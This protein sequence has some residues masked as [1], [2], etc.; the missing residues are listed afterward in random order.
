MRREGDSIIYK[1]RR[2]GRDGQAFECLKFRTMVPNA[3]QVLRD[4]LER[5]PEIKAEWVR[6]H[7]LRLRSEGD[8]TGAVSAAN[9]PGRAAATVECDAG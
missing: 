6:D 4:L 3:E 5:D 2:I 9:E 7:K 8:P 1:H